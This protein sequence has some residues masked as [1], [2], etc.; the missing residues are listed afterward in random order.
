MLLSNSDSEVSFIKNDLNHCELEVFSDSENALNFFQDNYPYIRSLLLST[1]IEDLHFLDIIDEFFLITDSVEIIVISSDFDTSEVITAMKKG[2]YDFIDL[3]TDYDHVKTRLDL[4][5]EKSFFP[6]TSSISS[7]ADPLE[8]NRQLINILTLLDSLLIQNDFDSLDLS[9]ISSMY[10]TWKNVELEKFGTPR[11]LIVEDEPEYNDM[12]YDFLSKDYDVYSVFDGE[13]CKD[14]IKT[15][16]FDIILLDLFLPDI[17]GAELAANFLQHNSDSK[18]IVI[19][20]FDI[21]REVIDVMRSGAYDLLHKPVLKDDLFKAINIAWSDLTENR[22]VLKSEIDFFRTQLNDDNKNAL[23][24]AL[25]LYY[26]AKNRELRMYDIYLFY[27]ELKKINF[28][29]SFTLPS[30][31]SVNSIGSFIKS[32]QSVDVSI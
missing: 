8:S 10:T 5:L 12:F 13:S 19:T 9:E 2:V 26:K 4:L 6:S 1:K 15:E 25:F 7:S 28:P 16:S 20:A 22:V 14:I 27:P 32:I 30:H 31:V 3:N 24:Q 11:L 17:S 23:L 21:T 18:I 29:S